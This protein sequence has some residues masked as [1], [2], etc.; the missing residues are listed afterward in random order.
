MSGAPLVVTSYRDRPEVG[1]QLFA[2]TCNPLYESAFP[3]QQ[4]IALDVI[5]ATLSTGRR[6]LYVAGDDA[7]GD[8]SG[9]ALVLPLSPATVLLEYMAV[10][11]ARRSRG[12]GSRLFTSLC[13]AETDAGATAV[14]LEIDDPDETGLTADA[15]QERNRRAAFHRRNSAHPVPAAIRYVPSSMSDVGPAPA[16]QL[17]AFTG[18]ATL[19]FQDATAALAAIAE[20]SYG[21]P[22]PEGS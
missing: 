21:Q 9:F 2:S 18:R 15:R 14:Y 10:D 3:P 13:E 4:R 5:G 16:L 11:E 12:V 17:L 22:S 6:R 1:H 8:V 20:H 19:S 7:A